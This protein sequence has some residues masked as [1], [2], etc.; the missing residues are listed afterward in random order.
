MR[1]LSLC[2]YLMHGDRTPDHFTPF[3]IVQ[4]IKGN[5]FNGY[6]RLTVGG[7][8]V[9]LTE[10]SPD[11]AVAWA[12]ERL[13]DQIHA[14]FEDELVTIVPVPGHAHVSKADVQSGAVHRLGLALA[15]ALRERGTRATA[16]VLLHWDRPI[17][18]AR[19][20]GPREASVLQRHLVAAHTVLTAHGFDVADVVF[21]VGR[22]VYTK[23]EPLGTLVEECPR[24]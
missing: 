5:P 9:R 7:E 11:V 4:A 8:S 19:D 20:G 2:E 3:N 14:E 6:S 1:V 22:T 21:A 24:Q 13:G 12:A 10:S 17:K 18:S 23:G 15:Q 16:F